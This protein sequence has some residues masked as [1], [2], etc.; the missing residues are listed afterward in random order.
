MTHVLPK[1]LKTIVHRHASVEARQ[2]V[3]SL[4]QEEKQPLT[5]QEIY[6]LSQRKNA[7]TPDGTPLLPSMRYL[8]KFVLPELAEAGK[9]EKVHAK[10]TLTQDE[11]KVLKERMGRP[12]YSAGGASSNLQLWRWQLKQAEP[13]EPEPV[14]Q[15]FG[16][17]VGVGADWSHLNKRRQRAREGKVKM[18]VEWLKELERARNEVINSSS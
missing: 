9:L 1:A 18:D 7:Q 5:V 15:V 3:L 13:K 6:N 12:A 2:F 4:L 10:V 17:E 16:K 8:K 11:L 14:K